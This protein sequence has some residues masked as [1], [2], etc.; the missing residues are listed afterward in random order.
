MNCT[1]RGKRHFYQISH[2]PCSELRVLGI[3]KF[4]RSSR[5]SFF[6]VPDA[7]MHLSVLSD[8]W[9]ILSASS[10][11]S[12]LVFNLWETSWWLFHKEG[13]RQ[14]TEWHHSKGYHIDQTTSSLPIE[15]RTVKDKAFSSNSRWREAECD[16]SEWQS[17]V[18]FATL[19]IF[20]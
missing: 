19:M 12:C 11:K 17:N 13:Q 8:K 3:N 20:I 18:I 10:W 6:W 7:S 2:W 9:N 15:K 16:Y 1:T 14:T 5:C 4:W